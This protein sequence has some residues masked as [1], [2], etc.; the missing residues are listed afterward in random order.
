[1]RERRGQLG[2]LRL[3]E[4]YQRVARQNPIR[5]RTK[6]FIYYNI[7]QI[8]EEANGKGRWP[9]QAQPLETSLPCP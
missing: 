6:S 7:E 5:V 9:E 1:M 3:L 2:R 4:S 8:D